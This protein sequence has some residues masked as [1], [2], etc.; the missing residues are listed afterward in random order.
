V[1]AAYIK[2]QNNTDLPTLAEKLDY[3]FKNK[4]IPN[5]CKTK[6]KSSDEEVSILSITH[7]LSLENFQTQRDY[8]GRVPPTPDRFR[9]FR[10]QQDLKQPP[11]R[12]YSDRC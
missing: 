1:R 4:L 7:S 10:P 6:T 11:E 2:Y 12:Q 5:A 9:V 3:M 8:H